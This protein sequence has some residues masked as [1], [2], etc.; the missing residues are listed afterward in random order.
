MYESLL[1]SEI[2]KLYYIDKVKQKEIAERFQITPMH[3]SRLLKKAESEGIVSFHVKVPAGIDTVLGKKI[4][5]K[6]KLSECIVLNV[7]S[8]ENVKEKIGKF[9]A[10]YIINLIGE[11]TIIGMSWGQTIYEFA[12]NLTYSNHSDCKLVQ[13]SGGF[14]YESNYLV[15]P[16]NI[17]RM[18]SE[19]LNCIPFFLN[20][21]FLVNSED[22]KE[23][24]LDDHSNK[25]LMELASKTNINIIGSSNLNSNGIIFQVGVLDEK[26]REELLSKGAIGEIAG[27]PIDKN[28]KEI[29]WSKSRLY[30]GVPLDTIKKASNVICL[31]GEEEKADILAAGMKGGYF[32]ILITSQKTA[33]ELIR[34]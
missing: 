5:D 20:A 19:K 1:L 13:L 9:A 11:D 29:S 12:R 10:S 8:T 25:Y 23:L 32:N 7:D 28:G 22:A 24:V 15:T 30:T 33:E 3:V 16:S 17:I 6:Y 2:A 4:K 27:F 34:M 31:S 26:D 14:M 18:V 21:P